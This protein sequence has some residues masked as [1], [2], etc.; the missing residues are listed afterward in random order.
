M[1]FSVC[2]ARQW[3]CIEVASTVDDVPVLEVWRR[4]QSDPKAILI[5]VRTRAEWAFV[6]MPDLTTLGRRPLLVEWLTFPDNRANPAFAEQL[7]QQLAE[8]GAGKDTDL[9]FICRSGGRSQQ[10]AKAMV[11]AGFQRCHNVA[12]GF[13][14]PLDPG[15]HRGTHS[16]WKVEGLPW[17]QG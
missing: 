2:L 1:P 8:A 4:L 7:S 11:A 17:V 14:G 9:Y 5:D 3:E 13:E 15:R 16:G 12:E 6:G 10:A